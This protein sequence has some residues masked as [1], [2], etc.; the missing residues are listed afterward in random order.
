MQRPG[1]DKMLDEIENEHTTML[2]ILS[3]KNEDIIIDCAKIANNGE[4]PVTYADITKD[5]AGN[6]VPNEVV[7]TDK[8]DYLTC[9][10][11]DYIF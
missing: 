10:S 9:Q 6:I 3:N 5:L 7:L 8:D 11:L 4:C 1:V 2:N